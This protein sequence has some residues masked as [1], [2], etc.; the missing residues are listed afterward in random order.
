[1]V[2]ARLRAEASFIGQQKSFVAK[3]L[4]FEAARGV[5]AGCGGKR[6]PAIRGATDAVLVMWLRSDSAVSDRGD[7]ARHCHQRGHACGSCLGETSVALLYSFA[8]AVEEMTYKILD[9]SGVRPDRS[10][11]D[12]RKMDPG[13]SRGEISIIAIRSSM[14]DDDDFGIRPPPR[15]PSHPDN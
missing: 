1:M 5:V 8:R 3:R 10:N 11:H 13:D 2:W 9:V 4:R 7:Q 12:D 6:I 14:D 15:P